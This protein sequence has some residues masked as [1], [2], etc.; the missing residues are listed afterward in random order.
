MEKLQI[1][2]KLNFTFNK[3]KNFCLIIKKNVKF[4]K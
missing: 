3:E 2:K 1:D 4:I